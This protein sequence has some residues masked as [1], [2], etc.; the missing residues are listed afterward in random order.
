RRVAAVDAAARVARLA[1]RIARVDDAGPARAALEVAVAHREAAR[2]GDRQLV[3]AARARVGEARRR[4][5]VDPRV[6]D[7][8]GARD[9]RG[10]ARRPVAREGEAEPRGRPSVHGAD[11]AAEPRTLEPRL[12]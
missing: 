9:E 2:R 11:L 5:D 4:V 3:A 10:D 8:R 7:D 1:D 6:R 12:G